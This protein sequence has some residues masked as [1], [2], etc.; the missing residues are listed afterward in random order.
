MLYDDQLSEE[1]WRCFEHRLHQLGEAHSGK[2]GSLSGKEKVVL[3]KRLMKSGDAVGLG[4][5]SLLSVSPC[6]LNPLP[7]LEDLSLSQ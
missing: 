7:V 4:L 2:A 6:S 5:L 3:F 1:G